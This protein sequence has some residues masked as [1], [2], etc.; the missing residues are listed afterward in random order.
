MSRHALDLTAH[1]ELPGLPRGGYLRLTYLLTGLFVI[2]LLTWSMI[3][4]VPVTAKARGQLV[5]QEDV[6]QVQSVRGGRLLGVEVVEGSRVTRGQVIARFDPYELDA[7]IT[8]ARARRG[9]LE[10]ERERLTAFIEDREPAFG[11]EGDPVA[12]RYPEVAAEQL[13]ALKRARAARDAGLLLIDRQVAETQAQ[14]RGMTREEPS[15]KRQRDA[16]QEIRKR[17]EGLQKQGMQSRTKLLELIESEGQFVHALVVLEGRE[18]VA[19]ATLARLQAQRERLK[20]DLIAQAQQ[21]KAIVAGQLREIDAEIDSF[22]ARKR[23]LVLTAPVDGLIKSVVSTPAG[24]VIAPGG[25]VAEIVSTVG[26]L[27]IEVR[28]SPR[29]IGFLTVGQVAKVKV[30][31]FDYSR[32]GAIEADISWIS[33]T[34]FTDPRG[35]AYY[36]VHLKPRELFVG[37]DKS[38]RLLPGMTVEADVHIDDRTIFEYLWKPVYV[39]LETSFSER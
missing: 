9:A 10:L 37:H 8:S 19:R 2:S 6:Q 33:P 1:E 4:S 26:E 31:A 30:D 3:E 17:I 29:D 25:V 27:L 36:T 5:P 7:A 16:A 14:L 39:T 15:L 35:A 34:T 23:R 13:A 32:Y 24:G 22:Q 11:K 21:R 20:A 18:E 38:H 28:A 12:A